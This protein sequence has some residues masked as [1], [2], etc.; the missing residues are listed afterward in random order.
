MASLKHYGRLHGQ[1]RWRL[2]AAAAR[3]RR[4]WGGW[5]WAWGG[6]GTALLGAALLWGLQ[7]QRL[8]QLQQVWRERKIGTPVAAPA[9]VDDRTHGDAAFQ[10]RLAR[11]PEIA[12]LLGQ[13][14]TQA[15][16]LGLHV[17]GGSYQW[18]Q[19]GQERFKRFTM[20]FPMKGAAPQLFEF[21]REA[22]R[23]HPGLALEAAAIK[24]GSVDAELVEA[25][26]RWVLYVA[27]DAELAGRKP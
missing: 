21:I 4:A 3:L 25:Q 26:L 10:A 8:E 1:W 12:E 20:S 22:R 15:T 17:D 9:D 23:L 13:L 5:A 27:P 7:T 14:L 16:A 18:Q 24:R 2:V 6:A 11:R 19:R